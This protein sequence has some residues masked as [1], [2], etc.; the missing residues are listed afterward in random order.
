MT[1]LSH[2]PFEPTLGVLADAFPSVSAC[3]FIILFAT[4]LPASLVAGAGLPGLIVALFVIGLGYLCPFRALG[5]R[6]NNMLTF[7]AVLGA[8]RATWDLSSQTSTLAS[9]VDSRHSSLGNG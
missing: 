9:R 8:S 1:V 3:G 5:G 7:D 6:Q 4:S 2:F